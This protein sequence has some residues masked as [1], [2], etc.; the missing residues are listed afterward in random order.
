MRVISPRQEYCTVEF[1]ENTT[2]LKKNA[3]VASSNIMHHNDVKNDA[4]SAWCFL[5][6]VSLTVY[7]RLNGAG[8]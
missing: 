6:F 1:K 3:T 8:Y 7:L 2:Q 5:S 4:T